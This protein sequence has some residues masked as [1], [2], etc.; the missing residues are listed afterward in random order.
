MFPDSPA[1]PPGAAG[2]TQLV[3]LHTRRWASLPGPVPLPSETT[4]TLHRKPGGSALS[5]SPELQ[6]GP[7]NDARA[8]IPSSEAAS[9][10]PASLA[11]VSQSYRARYTETECSR[12][13]RA[14]CPACHP[15]VQGSGHPR[16]QARRTVLDL[17][18]R[19]S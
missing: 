16:E 14:S 5:Q 8:G 17:L 10:L 15:R 12:R 18:T 3:F 19:D 2:Y 11:S 7:G 13:P 6:Q 9:Q 4:L 1:L